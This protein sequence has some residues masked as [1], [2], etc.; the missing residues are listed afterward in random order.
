MAGFA[1]DRLLASH[2]WKHFRLIM[3]GE[4][5]IVLHPEPPAELPRSMI[6]DVTRSVGGTAY[7][8]I[9]LFLDLREG[10]GISER[11]LGSPRGYWDLR[12]GTGISAR[13]L[14]SPSRGWIQLLHGVGCT[15]GKGG[16][17][18]PR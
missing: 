8:G 10:A 9:S 16:Q 17:W 12:E 15:S 2:E 3:I 11:V 18:P 5:T 14:G 6:L 4:T 1:V 13:A 7:R